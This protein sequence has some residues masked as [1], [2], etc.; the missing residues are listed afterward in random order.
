MNLTVYVAVRWLVYATYYI[1]DSHKRKVKVTIFLPFCVSYDLLPSVL[2]LG[3][4]AVSKLLGVYL[5]YDLN[6][7]QHYESIV[8]TCNQRLFLSTT[9]QVAQLSHRDRAAR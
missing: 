9:L 1:A 5:R 3:R 2:N 4:V 6:F 8:A 7:S